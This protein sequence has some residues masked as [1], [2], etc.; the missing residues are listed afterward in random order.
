M[1]EKGVAMTQEKDWPC[2]EIMKCNPDNAKQCPAYHSS[3]PC[4]EV[5][6][7]IDAYSFNICRD[8]IVY[9]I[10]QK[11]SEFSK[12]EISDIMHQKGISSEGIQCPQYKANKGGQLESN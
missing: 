1:F 9:V 11:S 7:K 4:W 5:M 12:E 10:K 8:C 2:W 3:S 6:R